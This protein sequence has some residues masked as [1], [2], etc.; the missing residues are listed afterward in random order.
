MPTI[1]A[2]QNAEVLPADNVL[3][4]LLA[5]SVINSP[6]NGI[7]TT[8]AQGVQ[9]TVGGTIVATNNGI[10]LNSSGP[11]DRNNHINVLETGIVIAQEFAGIALRGDLSS[12]VN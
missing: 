1:I 8:S 7:H 9:L 10:L 2:S 3:S 6:A 12:L 5:G 4:I 11:T